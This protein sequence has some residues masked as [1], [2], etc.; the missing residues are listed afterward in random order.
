MRTVG[1]DIFVFWRDQSK[2]PSSMLKLWIPRSVDAAAVVQIVSS[3][4]F[5]LLSSLSRRSSVKTTADCFEMKMH[6]KDVLR[7]HPF[8]TGKLYWSNVEIFDN[9]SEVGRT[10]VQRCRER[11]PEIVA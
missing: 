9:R 11:S 5:S 10:V 3:N 7:R 6:S 2:V 1:S 8:L 4:A